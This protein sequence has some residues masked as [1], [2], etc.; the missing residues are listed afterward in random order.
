MARDQV[1]KDLWRYI[2]MKKVRSYLWLVLTGYNRLNLNQGVAKVSSCVTWLDV[3]QYKMLNVRKEDPALFSQ[4][5]HH[6]TANTDWN[7]SNTC[8]SYSKRSEVQKRA[9]IGING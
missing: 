3:Y 1:L 5:L 7:Q 2:D 4:R 9:E 8:Y 6:G